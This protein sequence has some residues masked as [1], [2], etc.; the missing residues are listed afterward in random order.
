MQSKPYPISLVALII[1]IAIVNLMAEVYYWYW[2]MRWFDQPMHFLGGVWLASSALWWF[3]ARRGAALPTFIKILGVCLASSLG[4][5][6]L[7]EVLQAG[8]GLETAGHMSRV[9]G[10]LSD[11]FF[12]TIGGLAVA[13]GTFVRIRNNK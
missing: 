9:G 3:Y 2:R 10:T 4:I 8:L 6:L 5:G 11:L 12:D 13:M 1:F 7:W